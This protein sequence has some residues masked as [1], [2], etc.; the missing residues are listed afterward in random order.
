MRLTF[1]GT[2]SGTPSRTR[3]VSGIALQFSQ[4]GALWFFDCGEGTQHQTLRSPLRLSQLERVFVT[5]LHGDHLFGLPG[6]LASRSLGGGGVGPVTL[7]GPP[8]LGAFVECALAVSGTRLGYPYS[9]ETVTPGSVVADE[10]LQVIA[11]PVEHGTAAFAYAVIEHPRPGRLDVARARALGVP[12]GPLFGRLKNGESVTLPDG[13]VVAGA[14]MTGP[15][16][17]GRKIVFSGDTAYSR[18]L[19]ALAEGADVLV[20]EA[21]FREAEGDL[22]RR[23]HHSTAAMAAEAARAAGVGTLILTHLSPRYESEDRAGL[24][25]LLAEARAIFPDTHLAHDLWTYD[26]PPRQ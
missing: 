4:R 26:I 23:A 19:I 20:H 25:G 1:L 22:A 3:N 13:R 9:V 2:G 10:A 5:H 15:P 7:H 16:R 6:L 17:P 18:R 12:E 11:A 14:E 24:E 8:G 21:T